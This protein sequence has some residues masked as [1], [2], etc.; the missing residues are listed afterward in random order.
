[1]VKTG[2]NSSNSKRI[3]RM[4]KQRATKNDTKRN[5]SNDTK[6]KTS[7]EVLD[8]KTTSVRSLIFFHNRTNI[9][10]LLFLRI[11][12]GFGFGF[13]FRLLAPMG[14]R[15]ES[16]LVSGRRMKFTRSELKTLSI[17][18]A[19]KSEY[20]NNKIPLRLKGQSRKEVLI[21]DGLGTKFSGQKL[22]IEI[23]LRDE[24]KAIRH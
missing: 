1:M 11:G 3:P 18:L 24:K 4:P 10:A 22:G 16:L 14:S 20:L 19:I 12:I 8:E 5:K 6:I 23:F 2:P 15:R 17:L 13:G 9:F 7:I 21:K